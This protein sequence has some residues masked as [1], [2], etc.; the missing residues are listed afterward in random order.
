MSGRDGE[1]LFPSDPAPSA[2]TS[3]QVTEVSPTIH[4]LLSLE[5]NISIRNWNNVRE[6]SGRIV[7]QCIGD[8]PEDAYLLKRAARIYIECQC[9]LAGENGPED[10]VLIALQLMI[11]SKVTPDQWM[12][13]Q[14]IAA[15]ILGKRYSR[16]GDIVPTQKRDPMTGKDV[17]DPLL[18]KSDALMCA[19]C[20]ATESEKDKVTLQKC[21]LCKGVRYCSKDHQVHDWNVGG[22]KGKCKKE[23]RSW[24]STGPYREKVGFLDEIGKQMK[25]KPT[26][27]AKVSVSSPPTEPAPAQPVPMQSP[28]PEAAGIAPI[29]TTP[30][31]DTQKEQEKPVPPPSEAGQVSLKE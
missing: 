13:T 10:P 15:A 6:I 2:S 31:V 19:V 28:P 11:F 30:L 4:L 21:G 29:K 1:P 3:D 8:A 16:V 9:A 20:G 22:H 25:P 26:P 12:G 7:G 24:I 23:I 27:Q 5:Y 17:C 14:G 18:V